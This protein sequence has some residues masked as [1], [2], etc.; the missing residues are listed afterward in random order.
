M[1]SRIVFPAVIATYGRVC[2]VVV[3]TKTHGGK[4][5]SC[6]IVFPLHSLSPN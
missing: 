6:A 1:G 3:S 2:V 4:E 5:S